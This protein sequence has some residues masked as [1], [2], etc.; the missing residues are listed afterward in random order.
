M[1]HIFWIIITSIF[2]TFFLSACL[3]LPTATPSPSTE[4]AELTCENIALQ[5]T[6]LG[7]EGPF[8]PG[9]EVVISV[10]SKRENLHFEWKA[11]A[12]QFVSIAEN[13]SAAVY[14]VPTNTDKDT[15]TVSV[16]EI[17]CSKMLSIDVLTLTPTNTPTSTQT[18]TRTHTATLSPTFTPT[19][20][21]TKTPLPTSTFTPTSTSTP[22]PTRTSSTIIYPPVELGLASQESCDEIRF[23]WED[24]PLKSDELFT[25]R[26]GVN[27]AEEKSQYWGEENEYVLTV[28]NEYFPD[29][30]L[31]SW[32]VVIIRDLDG[33]RTGANGGWVPLSS[34]PISA[35]IQ[36][37]PLSCQGPIP[38]PTI[39]PRPGS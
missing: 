36:I 10:E 39:P 17:D 15:V 3:R 25:I 19:P 2:T 32:Y 30:A 38:T 14:T 27:G 5:L 11:E 12:G 20:T 13:T 23:R 16:Q 18:P 24:I 7:A 4:T 9:I 34:H 21:P 1:K 22:P 6:L 31:Y 28:G 35:Q 37:P 26:I 8:E 29:D 33:D